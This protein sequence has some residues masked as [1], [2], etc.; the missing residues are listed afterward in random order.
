MRIYELLP[1]YNNTISISTD[2]SIEYNPFL[3]DFDGSLKQSNWVP[4]KVVTLSRKPNND[5][6]Y[7]MP[8]LPV[9]SEKAKKL[10]QD[11][12]EFDVEFLPIL[13]SELNLFAMNVINIVDCVDWSRSERKKYSDGS[14]GRITKLVFDS[15]KIP[16]THIFK[17]KEMASTKVFVT[18]SFKIL[19]EKNNLKGLDFSMFY[20]SE[21][22]EEKEHQQ[23][24]EYEAALEEIERSKGMEFSYEEALNKTHEGL[25]VA[26]GKWKMQRDDQDRLWLGQLNLELSYQWLMPVYIPPILLTYSWHVVERSKFNIKQSEE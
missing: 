2:D 18:E 22:T 8:G 25:A 26:S 10:I 23:Q 13:H 16:N 15:Q 1:S 14:L 6:P 17:I 3:E 7:L 20:D 4:V 21:L 9:I 12:V 5:F 11:S 24:R 19:I